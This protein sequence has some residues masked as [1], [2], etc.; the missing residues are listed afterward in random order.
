MAR[1]KTCGAE[2]EVTSVPASGGS[3]EVQSVSG[4]VT[5]DT[6]VKRTGAASFKCDSAAGNVAAYAQ[7]FATGVI[8]VA[9]TSYW[10]RG[11]YCFSALPTAANHILQIGDVNGGTGYFAKITAAGKIQLFF[12]GILIGS[13]SAAT[14]SADSTTWYRIELQVDYDASSQPTA[15]QLRL[16]GVTVATDS[17]RAGSA[18]TQSIRLGWSVSAGAAG[19]GASKS[20]WVDDIAVNDST[21]AAQTS[22]PGDGKVVLLAPISD[23]AVG[24]GWTLG[25]GTAISGNSG[26][27]AVKNTPPLGVAD[28]AVGSDVKQIR[29]AASA[30][31]SNYDANLTTYTTAG[32]GASDTVNVLH[33][34]V[35]TAAPVVTSA[36]LG[37]F[38]VSANPVIANVNLGAG[39]T[40]G[41]FWSGVA[42]GTYPTGWKWSYGTVTYA[43]T[44]TVG[45]SPVARITQVTASTR[46]AVVCSMFV[47]CDYTPAAGGGPPT[48]NKYLTV[49]RQAQFRA[50]TR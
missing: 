29:N 12:G 27:T 46:I 49:P 32:V 17:G 7:V 36:K 6:A 24:T 14:I 26:S 30:A 23:S 50:V 3:P 16:D 19:P 48:I 39:G 11:C 22:W 47:Y 42:G 8:G 41:A 9:S 1:L 28:L 4:T 5:R 15:A 10:V 21:G 25:T 20:V 18:T 43:P 45:S 35:C 37:T 33:P 2:I 34:V 13:D 44:V 38:G 31:N 40:A